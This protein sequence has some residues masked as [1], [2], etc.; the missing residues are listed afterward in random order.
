[1][2]ALYNF[3]CQTVKNA[4]WSQKHPDHKSGSRYYKLKGA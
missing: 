3:L 4:T 1:V 2:E